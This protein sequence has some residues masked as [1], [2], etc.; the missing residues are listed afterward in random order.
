M[1]G[2][3]LRLTAGLALALCGWCAGDAVVQNLQQRLDALEA[4]ICLLEDIREAITFRRQDLGSLCQSLTRAERLQSREGTLQTA[5]PPPGLNKRE[6]AWFRECFSGMGRA[7]AEQE[8]QRVEQ[9]IEKF[10]TALGQC[11][12][13]AR[14]KQA[15]A[16]KLGL[17]A[18]LALGVLL[19]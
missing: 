8:C 19:L 3:P 6:A 15:L 9:Y 17:A 18:G 4:T 1:S 5:L 13:D 10:R 7:E 11:R 16:H 14:E 12:A 2:L